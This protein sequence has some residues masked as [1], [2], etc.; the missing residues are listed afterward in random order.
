MYL[1]KQ[2]VVCLVIAAVCSVL[3]AAY[4]AS[5]SGDDPYNSTQI[6]YTAPAQL[7]INTNGTTPDK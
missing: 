7:Y 4:M 2:S 5:P 6:A 1:R 3:L